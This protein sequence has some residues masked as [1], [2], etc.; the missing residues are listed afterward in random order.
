MLFVVGAIAVVE[1][2]P[3]V[4]T[5]EVVTGEVAVTDRAV[6]VIEVEDGQDDDPIE[7]EDGRWQEKIAHPE[8]DTQVTKVGVACVL[9]TLAEPVENEEQRV[10]ALAAGTLN[11]TGV[12]GDDDHRRL[13]GPIEEVGAGFVVVLEVLVE[14][15]GGLLEE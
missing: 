2:S 4:G 10:P 6:E 1:G 11:G 12:V 8:D 9:G 13:V 14:E 3:T 5:G 7:D 15:I